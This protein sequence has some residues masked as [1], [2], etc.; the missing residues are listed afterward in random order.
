MESVSSRPLPFEKGYLKIGRIVFAPLRLARW[1]CQGTVAFS[2]SLGGRRRLPENLG[3]RC[4][5]NIAVGQVEQEGLDRADDERQPCVI[6]P[7]VQAG[8][9]FQ[10]A[11][12]YCG[13]AT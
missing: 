3:R 6:Q 10:V 2:G 9:R 12:M 5:V 1:L 8:I 7:V 4:A 11:F 13:G